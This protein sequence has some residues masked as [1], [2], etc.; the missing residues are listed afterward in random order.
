MTTNIN[1]LILSFAKLT[2]V[3]PTSMPSGREMSSRDELEDFAEIDDH[4]ARLVLDVAPLVV[5]REDL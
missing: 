4:P 3:R 1:H 5:P 2:R